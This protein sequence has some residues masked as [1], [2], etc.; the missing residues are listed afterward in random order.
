MTAAAAMVAVSARPDPFRFAPLPSM[1]GSAYSPIF[2]R[3]KFCAPLAHT[4][5]FRPPRPRHT[6]RS[7]MCTLCPGECG[8][9]DSGGS[10]A[11][12]LDFIDSVVAR[13]PRAP[14]AGGPDDYVSPEALTAV[15]LMV[16]TGCNEAVACLVEL[17]RALGTPAFL[18]LARDMAVGG[19]TG[20]LVVFAWEHAARDPAALAALLEARDARLADGVNRRAAEHEAF[21]GNRVGRVKGDWAAQ[22]QQGAGA[23]GEAGGAGYI[24]AVAAA[25]AAVAAAGMAWCGSG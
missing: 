25:V 5:P 17:Q 1:S 22:R 3:G 6:L 4:A 11:A 12:T 9:G 20:P 13:L 2:V 14:G 10:E 15:A 19:L 18:S 24:V 8:P 16:A 7:S 23:R 21:A